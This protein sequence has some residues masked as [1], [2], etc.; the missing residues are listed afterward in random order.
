MIQAVAFDLDDTLLRSDRSLSP[1]TIRTLRRAAEDGVR[2]LLVSGRVWG[3]TRPYADQLG[4][5]TACICGNGAEVRL[6]DG[7]LL[8]RTALDPALAREAVIFAREQGCYIHVFEDDDFIYERQDG[9]AEGYAASTGLHALHAPDLLQR[10]HQPTPKALMIAPAPR[11][12]ELLPMAQ[13]HFQEKMTV[14]CSKPE[15]LEIVPPQVR[16]GNA[17]GWAAEHFG[18]DLQATMAFGDG[19]NDLSMLTAVGHGVAV[20]NSSPAVRDAVMHHC[21]TNDE[22]GAARYL[23]QYRSMHFRQ[24]VH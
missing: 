24:E 4:C 23:D 9:C 21:L 17:L 10:I 12:A 2:I 19:L 1:Y 14:T 15:Y 11:I 3:S 6:P 20:G 5:V 16:K 18:F 8:M 22:D 7:T 13:K